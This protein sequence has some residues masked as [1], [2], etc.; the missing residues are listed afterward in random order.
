M[1]YYFNGIPV[2]ISTMAYLT[3]TH[4]KVWKRR[5][6]RENKIKYR[7]HIIPKCFVTYSPDLGK[8]IIVHPAIAAHLN[9]YL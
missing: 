2:I 8:R 1:N 9:G 5:G 4:K 6:L 7:T 3:E